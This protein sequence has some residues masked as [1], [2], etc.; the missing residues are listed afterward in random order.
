M[1]KIEKKLLDEIETLEFY[2]LTLYYFKN[3]HRYFMKLALTKTSLLQG[4]A[5]HFLRFLFNRKGQKHVSVNVAQ[6]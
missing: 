1:M 2:M 3:I 6:A 4:R 5:F